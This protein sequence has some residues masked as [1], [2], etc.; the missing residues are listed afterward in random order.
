MT[1]DHFSGLMNL[2]YI[3]LS[4]TFLQIMVHSDWEPPFKLYAASF[5]SCHLGPKIPNWLRTQKSISS[6]DISNTGLIG[7][8][9]DW[10]WTT[11]SNA[12]HLDLS[13]PSQC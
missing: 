3:D 13:Q 11:F 7:K 5:S 2:K 12:F 8:I 6:L 4:D 1:E 9:P 10:F